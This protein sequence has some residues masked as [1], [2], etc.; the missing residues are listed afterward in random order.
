MKKYTALAIAFALLASLHATAQEKPTFAERLGWNKGDRVLIIHADDAGM[1]LASN[2]GIIETLDF[3]LVTSCSMM[4]P[5]PWVVGFMRYLEEN[6]DVDVGLHLTMTSEFDDYRWGPVAGKPAV[7]SLVDETGCLWDNNPLVYEHAT[8]DDVE[9]EIRA[10]IDRAL[11]MGVKV[12]HLDSHMGTLFRNMPIFERFMKVAV[13]K[14]IPIL[15]MA[16]HPAAETLWEAGLP[17]IDHLHGDSYDWKTTDKSQ[18]FIDAIRNLKPGITEMIVHPT[19]PDDVIGV[20]TGGRD[21]LYGDYTG[22]IDPAVKKAAEEEG[23]ILTTWRELKEH[24]D[25]AGN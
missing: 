11:T 1:S 4:M 16:G 7:P 8:P 21:H 25:K 18:H 24:R 2:R 19:K 9:T 14:Q 3:G 23:I 13:E 20:I 12:T 17:V 22:L 6:P 10:Q 5:T 15:M